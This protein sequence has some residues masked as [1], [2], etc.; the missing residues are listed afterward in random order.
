MKMGRPWRVPAE[1][2]RESGGKREK[3]SSKNNK[4][5]R[6]REDSGLAQLPYRRSSSFRRL[7]P[8][9]SGSFHLWGG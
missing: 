6:K 4:N 8:S 3:E 5:K 9:L 1:K 7:S 2:K